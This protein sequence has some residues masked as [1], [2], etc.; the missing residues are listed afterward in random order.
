MKYTLENSGFTV[1]AEYSEADVKGIFLPLL[2]RL[3]ELQRRKGSRVLVLL[4][5]PPA[6]GKSTLAA[7]LQLLSHT[8]GLCP[9][10]AI[11]MDGFHHRQEY[12]LSH[13]A[14]RNGETFPMARI[15]G[16]PIT[17]D[18][19]RFLEAVGR[20][21]AGEACGWPRYDRTLHDPVPDALR[22]TGDI[23]LLEG[24]Y[25]LLDEPGWREVRKLADYAI[26]IEAEPAMLRARVIARHIAG[27]KSPEEAA[28]KADESD[29]VNVRACLERSL[30]ADLRLR[31]RA[32]G[33]F[34]VMEE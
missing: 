9:L 27:G 10:T 7:L 23:V 31:L 32:D 15:K 3:T 26:G 28:R 21:A 16:A 13:T 22:V 33:T 20:V 2:R 4:A 11:G 12:L 29:M 34:E 19:P 25:L 30:P 8:P 17:Y 5:A 1:Q 18:L 14:Q 24:N 6:A